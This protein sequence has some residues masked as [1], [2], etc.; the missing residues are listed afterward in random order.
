MFNCPEAPTAPLHHAPCVSPRQGVRLLSAMKQACGA[1]VLGTLFFGAPLSAWSQSTHF[2]GIGR[3]ATGSEVAA[4]DID[5]RADFKGLPKGSGSVAKGQVIWEAQCASCHG[6]FGESN[7]VFTP[8]V[9][10]T[11]QSDIQT[12]RVARLTDASYPGRTTMMKVA[13]VATLWDYINRAMPWTQPKSLSADEV[14]GVTAFLLNLADVVPDNFVLSHQNIAEV[15]AKLPNRNGMTTKHGLWPGSGF[16][17]SKADVKAVACMI[18]CGAAPTVR[19]FLPDFARNAHGDLAQQNRPVGAQVGAK[20]APVLAGPA[21]A[22]LGAQSPPRAPAP[23]DAS[24]NAAAVALLSQHN[25]TACHGMSNK[26]LGPSFSEVAAKYGASA[27]EAL[28]LKIK[29]GGSG[30]WGQIPMPAQAIPDADARAI[31]QWLAKGATP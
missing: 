23:I 7:H 29:A 18:N 28:A 5:V 31:A 22:A 4:W 21:T 3:P 1:M 16:G 2:P 25:C 9:G 12:G 6:V 11:T 26:L 15:Q 17:Q 8:I 27:G 24:A 30:V 14:Y 20:T 10:G 13:Y 19:S